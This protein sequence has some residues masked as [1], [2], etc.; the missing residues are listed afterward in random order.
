[1]GEKGDVKKAS[2]YKSTGDIKIA[3]LS[4]L[5]RNIIVYNQVHY[6]KI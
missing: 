4:K 2:V 6:R 5:Q 3:Y 1:M